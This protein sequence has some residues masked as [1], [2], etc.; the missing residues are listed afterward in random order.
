MQTYLVLVLALFIVGSQQADRSFFAPY[1]PN[2]GDA[3]MHRND[4]EFTNAV[5]L[6]GG[7]NFFNSTRTFLYVDNNGIITLDAQLSD[8]T[9]SSLSTLRIA[10]IAPYWAD[11]DTRPSNGGF[12][13]YRSTLD[14]N[15]A[16]T[17][18][19]FVRATNPGSNFVGTRTFVASWID[20]GYYNQK[21]NKRC[22]FQCILIADDLGKTFAI[23]NYGDMQWTTGDASGGSNGLGG[24]PAAVGFTKGDNSG[25]YA[26]VA[27]SLTNA[28][29]NIYTKS[30]CNINGVAQIGQYI[31]SVSEG[32]SVV[33]CCASSNPPVLSG[34]PTTLNYQIQTINDVPDFSGTVT[35]TY[36]CTSPVQEVIQPVLFVVYGCPVTRTWT[37]TDDCFK[38][39]SVQQ[40]FTYPEVFS[41]PLVLTTP[42]DYTVTG[43]CTNPVAPLP[44]VSGQGTSN[45]G[46]NGNVTYQDSVW[47]QNSGSCSFT[48]FWQAQDI[49]NVFQRGQQTITIIQELTTRAPVT[50]ARLTTS[51]LTTQ[52]LTTQPLTTKPLTTQPLTTQALTTQPLTTQPLTTQP[53]TTQPLTTQ[54]LTT[55]PLT[56][57]PLTTQELT[58]QELTTQELTTQELTTQELTT[59][60]LT[61]QE[62]TT[63]ELTTQELTT[64]ELTTQELTTQP[65]TTQ[66]LTTTFAT[67]ADR[68]S[69]Y[70]W[71]E[72]QGWFCSADQTGYYQCLKGPWAS[73]AVFQP[74][75]P[76]TSCKC[77]V[78]VECS[79][80]GICTNNYV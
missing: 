15:L 44:S 75:P 60:E 38:Q 30:N 39:T 47:V 31:Y 57:Q 62:L 23:F 66:P 3:T 74:C 13:Y 12:V 34:T 50:S 32:V 35:A 56:T 2:A 43:S 79:I 10:A 22:T 4:D 25:T 55:Q 46:A 26:Q 53:L 9:P 40:T 59:Q 6:I 61:T 17:T 65:L 76:S 42:P 29:I 58:T 16:A 19:A 7:M 5:L 54:P 72:T 69:T 14:A 33:S 63:Q 1:G 68:C 45:R 73:Q 49:C 80:Y 36:Q 70:S 52:P 20:V 71:P 8:Y 48:R 18:S 51:P 78:G 21:V 41:T 11:V 67:V 27:E 28:I 37:A 77:A 24:V 64:Q